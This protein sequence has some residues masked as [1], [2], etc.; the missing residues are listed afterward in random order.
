MFRVNDVQPRHELITDELVRFRGGAVFE[1][2]LGR[3]RWSPRPHRGCTRGTP[4]GSDPFA[5]FPSWM[6]RNH[7]VLEFVEWL[8]DF[9]VDVV[10]ESRKTGFYGLDLYSLYTSI[11]EVLRYLPRNGSRADGHRT[12][13]L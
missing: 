5:R 7:E 2:R 11:E 1:D 8:R 6:W 13:A 10:N 3:Y 12:E 9:Y 4:R